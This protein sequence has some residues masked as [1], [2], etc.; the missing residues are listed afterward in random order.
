MSRSRSQLSERSSAIP[1]FHVMR[2]L[3]R[4][5]EMEAA[6]RDL[7]HMEVGEPDFPTAAPILAAGHRA[8]ADGKTRYTAARG[9]PELREAIAGHYRRRFSAAVDPE[10]ILVTPGASG[11]LQLLLAA[12]LDPGDGVLI[13]DPGYPCNRHLVRLFGGIPRLVSVGADTGYQLTA[14]HLEAAWRPDVRL[15]MVATPSNPTGTLLGADELRRLYRA[16]RE[17]GACLL[18]DEIYQGLVYGEPDQTALVEGEEGL[19]VVNSFSKYFGMTGWRLGWVVAPTD[20]I[21]TLDRLAQNLY[22]A[23]PTPSQYAALAAFEPETTEIFESR[24]L[25][26]ERRR[27]FLLPALSELGLRFA[28]KPQGA[29]YLYARC[30]DLTDDSSDFA[31]RLLEQEAVAVTPGRDF[32]SNASECHLRFAYTTDL[33]ALRE[34]VRRIARFI[35][36]VTPSR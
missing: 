4:A 12:L 30:D 13:A 35:N 31:E 33:D 23:A 10:R 25:E 7:V 19:F 27:D 22:L 24:R 9:L 14:D 5:I 16:V 8:L 20:C 21:D 28:A 6:G 15:V 17:R 18:V 32:G 36:A 1:P 34:G 3:A 11:G 2:L 26:L 29:F